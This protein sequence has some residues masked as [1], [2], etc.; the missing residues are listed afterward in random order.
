MRDHQLLGRIGENMAGT[1]EK[2]MTVG[3]AEL[4][5]VKELA[6]KLYDDEF[7][8]FYLLGYLWAM[9]TQEQQQDVLESFQ[10]YTKEK[11]N[12]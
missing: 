10:R 9:L 2:Q 4:T 7:G 11:E 1:R 3:I 5:E 8:P 6:R 12:K